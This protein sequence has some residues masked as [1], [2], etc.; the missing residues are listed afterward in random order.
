MRKL[1]TITLQYPP[2]HLQTCF[3]VNTVANDDGQNAAEA[4]DR[5]ANRLKFENK[6]P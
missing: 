3:L 2:S 5:V 4:R 1:L 6:P